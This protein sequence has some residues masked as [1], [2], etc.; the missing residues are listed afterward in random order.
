VFWTTDATTFLEPP[1]SDQELDNYSNRDHIRDVASSHAE[2]ESRVLSRILCMSSSYGIAEPH[3][4]TPLD[5]AR[6]VEGRIWLYQDGTF[7][8]GFV[9]GNSIIDL[10]HISS[11]GC[12][13]DTLH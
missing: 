5:D 9:G 4:S 2:A 3:L 10:R 12:V 7:G 11:A 1:F 8:F 13:L 6:N